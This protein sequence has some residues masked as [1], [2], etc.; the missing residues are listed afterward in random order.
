MR[1]QAKVN[2]SV[3]IH[4]SFCLLKGFQNTTFL[5]GLKMTS[6]SNLN[7]LITKPKLVYYISSRLTQVKLSFDLLEKRI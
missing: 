6:I 3:F 4:V 2:I 7:N 5:S 1:R